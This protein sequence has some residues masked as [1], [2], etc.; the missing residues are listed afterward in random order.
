MFAIIEKELKNGLFYVKKSQANKVI[1]AYEPL[2]A[3]GTGRACLP[4]DALIVV[5]YI[6]KI[7]GRMFGRLIGERATVLYGGSISGANGKDYLKEKH[8]DGL[9]V[10]RS[11]LLIKDFLQIVKN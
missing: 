9:L 8:I 5:L 4:E 3:I 2:W 7:I 11:S 6:K 10:G 1:I